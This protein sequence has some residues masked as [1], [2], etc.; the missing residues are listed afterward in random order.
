MRDRIT[1]SHRV[2]RCGRAASAV[3][4]ENLPRRRPGCAPTG[5][6]RHNQSVCQ[7]G[8][9]RRTCS[10]LRLRATSSPLEVR[11]SVSNQRRTFS[12][13]A[14]A[15]GSSITAS[16]CIC[17]QRLSHVTTLRVREHRQLLRAWVRRVVAAIRS[18]TKARANQARGVPASTEAG[19]NPRP[20]CERLLRRSAS[21]TPGCSAQL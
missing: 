9:L 17:G 8:R 18:I 10:C 14:A 12:P 13:P 19:G 2:A 16:H 20:S 4:H 15:P 6:I 21:N 11:I 5:Q 3:T 7:A 1:A